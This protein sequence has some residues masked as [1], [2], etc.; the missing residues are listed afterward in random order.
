MF[1]YFVYGE[2]NEH[3]FFQTHQTLWLS[4]LDGR[5]LCPMW[6]T[7]GYQRLF[8]RWGNAALNLISLKSPSFGTSHHRQ[9]FQQVSS[10]N[11]I[12]TLLIGFS[13]GCP[14]TCS[15]WTLFVLRRNAMENWPMPESIKKPAW[16]WMKT[17]STTWLEST[18]VAQNAPK[19]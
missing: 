3:Q 1:V 16:C 8:S 6:I 7:S 13:C 15:T 5:K 10:T 9:A 11:Q 4:W 12:G 14:A 18:L 2:P 17:L 19:R